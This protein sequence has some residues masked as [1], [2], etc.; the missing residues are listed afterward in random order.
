M[1][2]ALFFD[3]DGTLV[4]FKTHA[5]PQSTI[6]ALTRAKENGLAVFISTG[7]PYSLINNLGAISHLIDGYITTNG[8]YTFIGKQTISIT[9]IPEAD[10]DRILSFSDKEHATC[11]VV[12]ER[13]IVMHN[14]TKKA[15]DIFSR[16]LDVHGLTS[17][18]IHEGGRFG[19][20]LQLTPV[21]TPEQQSIL[22]NGVSDVVMARWCPDFV[23]ITAKG[24][25]KA[26]GLMEVA[27][28]CG[29][30][31]SETMAFGDGGNDISI[32]KNAG[33]GVAMG[34]ANESLKPVADY[35]TSSVDEDGVLKA[36]KHFGII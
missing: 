25:D 21:I 22:E 29:Y 10:V 6:D 8:A 5:I 33:I 16:L 23:D 1:I 3:I 11:M 26:K 7:R 14:P 20:V 28:H 9:P 31:I 27:R 17:E 35:I 12:G 24:V 30:D 2:K 19:N 4:S 15:E 13:D 32:V 18:V 34:N 36:M